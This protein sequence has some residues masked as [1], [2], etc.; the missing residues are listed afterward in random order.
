M[1]ERH[2]TLL[3]CDNPDETLLEPIKEEAFRFE[4]KKKVELALRPPTQVTPKRRAF[5]A[6][7]SLQARAV[8][9]KVA[10]LK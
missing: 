7:L 9:K 5:G 2:S 1:E 4:G 8:A 3:Y 10:P 6:I